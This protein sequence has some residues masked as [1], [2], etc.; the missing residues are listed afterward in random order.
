MIIYLNILYR[1][2]FFYHYLSIFKEK[3]FRLI[4]VYS[5]KIRSP[6]FIRT[7][8]LKVSIFLASQKCPANRKSQKILGGRLGG[9]R[10]QSIFYSL[11]TSGSEKNIFQLICIFCACGY[12]KAAKQ[13][14]NYLRIIIDIFRTIIK[15]S[16]QGKKVKSISVF[17][18]Y[19]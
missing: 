11:P 7:E 5:C 4:L 10:F 3:N 6:A 1:N 18:F 8:I 15:Q 12:N 13:N 17:T 16:I 14:L 9:L 19:A 2:W